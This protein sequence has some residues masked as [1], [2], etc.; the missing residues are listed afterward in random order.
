MTASAT[1]SR[2]CQDGKDLRELTSVVRTTCITLCSVGLRANMD[3]RTF[4][5]GLG[6]LSFLVVS[7]ICESL[8]RGRN[9]DGFD[10]FGPYTEP[11]VPTREAV[12]YDTRMHNEM[13]EFIWEH[14]HERRRGYAAVTRISPTEGVP[15]TTT[16]L[17]HPDKKGT[18]QIEFQGKLGQSSYRHKTEKRLIAS[19]QRLVFDA[20]AGR[21]D[22]PVPDGSSLSASS[23]V[24]RFRDTKGEE[25]NF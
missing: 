5:R 20:A 3:R 22:M 17:I 4:Q 21:K 16:Y 19:A 18:W 13:R 10:V 11:V 6:T 2:W 8:A 7:E 1:E 23:F 12:D 9:L 14:W 25:W 15:Y 24:L